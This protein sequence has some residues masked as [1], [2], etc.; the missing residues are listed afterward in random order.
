MKFAFRQCLRE[1]DKGLESQ[2]P[3]ASRGANHNKLN[4]FE[5]DL[6]QC[7][8]DL[9]ARGNRQYILPRLVVR[10][11]P[12][13]CRRMTQA[14][15]GTTYCGESR[16]AQRAVTGRNRRVLKCGGDAAWMRSDDISSRYKCL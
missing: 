14:W 16:A 13:S 10:R 6:D 4:G 7:L 5:F 9:L 12:A 1:A 15:I 8:I 11:M 3:F 2:Q